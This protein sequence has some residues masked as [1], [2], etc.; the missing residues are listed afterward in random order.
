[1]IG[2][3]NIKQLKVNMIM[4]NF[5]GEKYLKQSIDSFLDQDYINKK[6]IIVDNKS[7]DRSHE[8]INS[9]S[10]NK[11]IL[12]VKEMDK[13]ISNALNI[14][15]NYLDGDIIGYLGSDDLLC[16][17]IF[18]SLNYYFNLLSVD[19]ISCN[20][21]TYY[22]KSKYYYQRKNPNYPFNKTNLLKYGTLTGLQNI[23]FSRQIYDENSFDEKNK[24]SMDY[25]FYLRLA[26][27]RNINVYNLDQ[28]ATINIFDDN[29]S[30]MMEKKQIQEAFNV[31]YR[32]CNNNAERLIVN[33]RKLIYQ[34]RQFKKKLSSLLL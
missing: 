16:K 27:T 10:G 1:M 20:S 9:Y 6:L 5:N 24:Y 22:V 19:A 7:T 2:G 11:S 14:A 29:I 3:I 4:P 17:D 31:A 26:N 33:K 25:E 15:S 34:Y 12:W 8:I 21:I 30:Y 23:F 18:K 28:T 13:G 32:Y